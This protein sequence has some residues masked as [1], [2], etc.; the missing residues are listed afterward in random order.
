MQLRL[1]LGGHVYMYWAVSTLLLAYVCDQPA[2]SVW[3]LPS[4]C[5]CVALRMRDCLHICFQRPSVQLVAA[6]SSS[7]RWQLDCMCNAGGS[8][9]NNA[10][11]LIIVVYVYVT[12]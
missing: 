2:D 6:N 5:T 8:Y 11:L 3:L 1:I 7:C 9:A 4:G 10:H 12:Q